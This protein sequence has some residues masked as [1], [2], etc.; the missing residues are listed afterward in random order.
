LRRDLF[1]SDLFGAFRSS[2]LGTSTEVAEPGTAVGPLEVRIEK[3]FP[4]ASS[5]VIYYEIHYTGEVSG[6]INQRYSELKKLRDALRLQNTS[7]CL[8]IW[9]QP[10][11]QALLAAILEDLQLAEEAGMVF[12]AAAAEEV[13]AEAE[14]DELEAM[15][16]ARR[17]EVQGAR[18]STS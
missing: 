12:P 15:S 7:E 13:E 8:R 5:S 4:G 16:T 6:K 10:L 17:R 11:L 9:K 2:E 1:S 18:C 3:F 14:V